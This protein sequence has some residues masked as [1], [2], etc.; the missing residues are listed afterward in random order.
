LKGL[1]RF[2]KFLFLANI[3]A[4]LLL[5]LACVT[6]TLSNEAFSFLTFLSLS[7][8]AL[9]L[10]NIFFLLYWLLRRKV[11]FALPSLIVL[12]L[13]YF[14]LGTFFKFN[15]SQ[16]EMARDDLKVMTYN[17]RLFNKDGQ[18]ENPNVLEDIQAFIKKEDP[19]IICF[20]EP[21]YKARD[22]FKDYPYYYL[23][24][25][26]M[27]G[28]GILGIFSKFPIVNQGIIDLPKTHSNA[29]FADIAYGQ[30]T[31]RVY[32]AH[33]ESL[34]ITPGHRTL[35]TKRSDKVL[36]MLNR[37]F[38]KQ[39]EQAK[40]LQKHMAT[41]KYN[42]LFCGDL[43]NNQFS[44]TYETIKGD[45]QDT[46]LEKGSGYGRTLYFHRIPVRIDFILA[47]E[48]FEVK[49]HKN[50]DVKYSDHY[51]VMASFQLRGD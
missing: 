47:D 29:A 21:Y 30:D 25:I 6:P 34:G 7:V 51:P 14:A 11:K 5:L 43:N 23:K 39:Q 38:K 37:A 45:F 3:I 41:S 15:F 33:L 26:D 42:T 16:E 18:L 22:K 10:V 32:N 28:K 8:P 27:Q 9:V 40:I 12:I 36:K 17:V 24:Y 1:S 44:N 50:Y 31:I 49:S 48:S 20:Q 46:F 2:N 13:G 19:D 35:R 4:I